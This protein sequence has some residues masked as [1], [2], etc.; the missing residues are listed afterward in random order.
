MEGVG[1]KPD[2]HGWH[3]QLWWRT[4]NQKD[5]FGS[6]SGKFS[7]AAPNFDVYVE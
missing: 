3:A 2:W 6:S 4:W 7:S 5:F 1:K